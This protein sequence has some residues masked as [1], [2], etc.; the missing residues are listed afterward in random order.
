MSVTRQFIQYCIVGV[1]SNASAYCLFLVMI[2]SGVE[3]KVS[4]SIV[5]VLAAAF[6]FWANRK[7]T[8]AFTGNWISNTARFLGAQGS[9]YGL[10]LLILL[11]FHDRLHWPAAIVQASAILIVAI[12]M[13]LISK[14][15]VFRQSNHRGTK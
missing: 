8:F 2:A 12:Y 15:F 1:V 3:A 10:N 5:Y 11:M 13:F 6:S 9:G 14:A 4:M 7:W